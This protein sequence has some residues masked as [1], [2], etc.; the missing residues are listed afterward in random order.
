MQQHYLHQKN[1]RM[2]NKNQA[3]KV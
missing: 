1:Y 3:W 2:P